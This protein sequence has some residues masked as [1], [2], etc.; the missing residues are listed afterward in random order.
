MCSI[1][2]WASDPECVCGIKMKGAV[3]GC[4]CDKPVK[5]QT[6][7]RVKQPILHDDRQKETEREKQMERQRGGSWGQGIAFV[8]FFSFYFYLPDSFYP[9]LFWFAKNPLVKTALGQKKLCQQP[10]W[11]SGG[12]NARVFP[13]FAPIPSSPLNLQNGTVFSVR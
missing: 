1:H 12:K 11:S 3:Q 2:H 9:F 5:Y 6:G 13:P 4:L 8:W 7:G 10:A